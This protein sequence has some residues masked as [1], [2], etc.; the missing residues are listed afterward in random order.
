VTLSLPTVELSPRPLGLRFS[1]LS[2]TPKEPANN[3]AEYGRTAR[4]YDEYGE[5][6]YVSLV[7]HHARPLTASHA[8]SCC[9]ASG[10]PSAH[11]DFVCKKCCSSPSGTPH[12]SSSRGNHL[13]TPI[14]R[15]YYEDDLDIS[16]PDVLADAAEQAAIMSKDEVSF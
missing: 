11:S 6:H 15:A 8:S 16:D 14:F 2:W 12:A 7:H 3:Q 10:T 5:L 9:L 13:V 4:D 1:S